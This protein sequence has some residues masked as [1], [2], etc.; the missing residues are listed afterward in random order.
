M[1]STRQ[2]VMREHVGAALGS[3]ATLITYKPKSFI[4]THNVIKEW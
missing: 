2:T 3:F 4:Q 1:E